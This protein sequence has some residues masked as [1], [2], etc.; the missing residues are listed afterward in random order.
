MVCRRWEVARKSQVHSA[1]R[2]TEYTT[3]YRNHWLGEKKQKQEGNQRGR[4]LPQ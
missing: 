2:R 1:M 3:Y 4:Q